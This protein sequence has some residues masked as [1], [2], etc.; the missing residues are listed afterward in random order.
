MIEQLVRKMKPADPD[1]LKTELLFKLTT[2]KSTATDVRD[3]NAYLWVSL[4]N[5]AL[6]ILTRCG[7]RRLGSVPTYDRVM[8]NRRTLSTPEHLY[9]AYPSR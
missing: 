2:L 9:A 8:R 4:K 7:R 3:W 5:H 1:Y 6:N